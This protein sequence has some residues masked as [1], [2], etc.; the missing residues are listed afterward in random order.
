M[1]SSCACFEANA[2]KMR[3]FFLQN[4][5]ITNTQVQPG[6][7]TAYY[8]TYLCTVFVHAK[9]GLHRFVP[10]HF[11]RIIKLNESIFAMKSG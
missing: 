4:L 7:R 8:S 9:L 1:A 6:L 10:V 11:P 2:S 5:A 3:C